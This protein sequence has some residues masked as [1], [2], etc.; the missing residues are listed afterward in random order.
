MKKARTGA[1]T[2][3]TESKTPG[4][5]GPA[6][7]YFA[8]VPSPG[9]VKTRLTPPLTS[10]EASALYGAFLRDGV[11]PIS[12]YKTMVYGWPPEEL[13]DLA[14]Y[15]SA[16]L[17]V[18]PQRGGDLWERLGHAISDLFAE[19]HGPVVVRNTD[20]P[21]LPRARVEEAV[22]RCGVDDVVFGPDADG[23]F[24]L[25][26][27]GSPCPDLLRGLPVS[28]DGVL[29]A[30]SDRAREL[31]REVHMLAQECDVDTFDDLIGMWRERLARG[32]D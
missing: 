24:Y 5:T 32:A 17:E 19:G 14:G 18:R 25:I 2:P 16:D 23:G 7:V 4:S 20:S 28:S 29:A 27:L 31:G 13:S 3:Q 21:D 6:V 26:A 10:S 1:V 9:R 15:L 12:D 30:A 11:K 22:E 8:K